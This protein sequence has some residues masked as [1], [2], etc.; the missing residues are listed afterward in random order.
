MQQPQEIE[1]LHIL[2]YIRAKIAE[3][4]KVHHNMKNFQVAMIMGLTEAAISQ[5]VQGKRGTKSFDVDL[6]RYDLDIALIATE[7]VG[8]A[9]IRELRR[10]E[11]SSEA[12][13]A[14]EEAKT[15][16]FVRTSKLL[17]LIREDNTLCEIHRELGDDVPEDCDLCN[18]IRSTMP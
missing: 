4:L 13:A 2:P 5:Y 1:V 9:H 7:I 18:R 12:L 11:S 6:S 14:L 17:E 8:I 3:K 16:I 15:L 10:R